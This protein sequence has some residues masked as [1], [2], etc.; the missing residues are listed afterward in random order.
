MLTART[1]ADG[2]IVRRGAVAGVDMDRFAKMSPHLFK[3]AEELVILS[4]VE[5]IALFTLLPTVELSHFSL[6]LEAIP[7]V[8]VTNPLT[9]LFT[10]PPSQ[11]LFH[12][13]FALL[14]ALLPT[15]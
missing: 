12:A 3:N 7:L 8:V 2:N 4:L 13:F 10:L 6:T 1:A 11:E 14:I 15:S 9:A 5:L